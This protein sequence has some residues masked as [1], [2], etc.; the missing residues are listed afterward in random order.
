MRAPRSQKYV[1]LSAG[2][3]TFTYQK[4]EK[5]ELNPGKPMN[6]RLSTLVALARAFE[7]EP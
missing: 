6:P 1:A 2:I 5:G 3:S 4:F 7:V